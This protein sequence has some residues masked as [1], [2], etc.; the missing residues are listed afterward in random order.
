[1][2]RLADKFLRHKKLYSN[3]L[4]LLL[5]RISTRTQHEKQTT[6]SRDRPT[7]PDR[8]IGN[9]TNHSTADTLHGDAY[10]NDQ[11][12]QDLKKT[13]IKNG[14]MLYTNS[15][16]T[17]QILKE[18]KSQQYHNERLRIAHNSSGLDKQPVVNNKQTFIKEGIQNYSSVHDHTYVNTRI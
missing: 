17:P 1:M 9:I 10:V 12:V 15:L 4:P 13:D 7:H 5:D 2:E 14:N 6:E 18:Y 11:F 8:Y 16:H 3:N